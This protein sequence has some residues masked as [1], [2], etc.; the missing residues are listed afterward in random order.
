MAN[1]IN[2]QVV[3][4]VVSKEGYDGWNKNIKDVNKSLKAQSQTLS[5][6]RNNMLSMLFLG[7]GIERM[8]GGQVKRVSEL[9]GTSEIINTFFTVALIK[10]MTKITSLLVDLL[11]KFLKLPE[12]IQAGVGWGMIAVTGAGM[13]IS[14]LAAVAISLVSISSLITGLSAGTVVTGTAIGSGLASGILAGLVGAAIGFALLGGAITLGLIA[15]IGLDKALSEYQWY[16]DLKAFVETPLYKT[17]E[18]TFGSNKSAKIMNWILGEAWDWL[19]NR[20]SEGIT[21]TTGSLVPSGTIPSG[22][23][24]GTHYS[25]SLDGQITQRAL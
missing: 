9:T 2:Y 7:M 21:I 22:G 8:F 17:I 13:I 23:A 16:R 5:N 1:T 15:I 3:V 6:V 14:F 4:D 18:F 12:N 19:G 24:A 11:D 10:P 25:I 20:P